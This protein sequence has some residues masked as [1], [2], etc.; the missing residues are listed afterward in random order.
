[1]SN[2]N[3]ENKSKALSHFKSGSIKKLGITAAGFP[4]AISAIGGSI[5]AQKHT[6]GLD[7]YNPLYTALPAGMAG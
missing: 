1:M 2:Q 7:A 6:V 3:D 5:L 4:A